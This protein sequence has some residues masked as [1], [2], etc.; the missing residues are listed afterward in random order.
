MKQG[1][2]DAAHA[3]AVRRGWGITGKLA[4]AIVVSVIIAVAILLGVVYVQMSRTLLDKSEDLLQTT[5]DRTVQETRAWINRTLTMLETQRDTIQYEDMEVPAMMD[6]VRHT[7]GQNDAYPAGLYVALTDGTLYHS[8]F[9]PG[10]DYD[11]LGKTWYQDGIKSDAF[12]FGDTYL[13]EDSQSYVVGA[14]GVLKS[15]DGSVRG[16]AAA[17][18]SLDSISQIVSQVQIEDTGGIFLVDTRTDTIIG[19]KDKTITGQILS[20]MKDGM[21]AYASQQIRSGKAGLSLYENTYI[22]VANV[23]GCDWMAVAY[24]SRA[25]VLE[26]LLQ[27]TASMLL[28]AGVAILVLIIL[29]V[30]QVRRVIGR[31]VKELSMV[32][33]QIAEGQLN[34]TIH[35]HSRDELGVL[36]DD[37]NRVTVRLRD[38][39]IYITE[40]AEKLREI[41]SGNL[42]FTLENEYSGEFQKIKAALDEISRSLNAAM[43]QLQ[44][45]SRDVAAGAE[46]VSAGAMTLSQGSTEQ[47]AEVDTLA[48][49]ISA[50]SDSVHKIAKGAQ[51][52]SLISQQVKTGILSSNEKMQNMTVVIQRISEK[53]TEIHKIVKTIEDIAFQTNILALNAAVEAAR[54]GSAGKGFA[55]VADEVRAL[56]GKSSAAAQETT[57]LLSQTVA[58]MDEGV[59]AAQDTADSMLKVVNHADEMSK[60]IDGIANYT[61]EQDANTEE[62]TR[63]IQQISTVVQTNVST[64]EASAAASEELSGQALMLRELVAKFRLLDQ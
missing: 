64:A 42:A 46:Q 2:Q 45:A 62:I 10:P 6:Y 60:L 15:R 4:S 20:Q 24:V 40:I 35:Y 59:R 13:D 34:Q 3:R 31:P 28:V 19:H 9:V 32:A 52:A 21:Y 8:S 57:V 17:D 48:E 39:V 54:A 16:V 1:K 14:S 56:A 25:E 36:A 47:A 30:I 29:V 53:S 5:T 63:G 27:L 33:T 11:P 58:S 12:M 41:A 55:V 23:P 22:Q 38:Y 49:H 51:E 26:E 43:G 50:V 44:A 18:V 7:A 61:K 37:F